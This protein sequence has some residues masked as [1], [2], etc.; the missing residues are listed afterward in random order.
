MP[1]YRHKETG[2]LRRFSSVRISWDENMNNKKE[3]CLNTGEVIS[4]NWDFVPYDGEFNVKMKK[5]N[6]DGHGMR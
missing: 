1:N 2:E 6:R 3:T 4:D 5:A